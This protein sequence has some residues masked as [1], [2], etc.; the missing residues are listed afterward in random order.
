L[1][2]NA[3]N[4]KYREHGWKIEGTENVGK[5]SVEIAGNGN[6]REFKDRERK[7]QVRNIREKE[8]A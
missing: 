1:S 2:E 3:R 6:C 7:I 4:I 8:N 5:A